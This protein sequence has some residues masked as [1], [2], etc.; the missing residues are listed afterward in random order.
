MQRCFES[1]G[2]NYSLHKNQKDWFI[3]ADYI[4]EAPPKEPFCVRW[5]VSPTTL[6]S[7]KKKSPRPKPND[8]LATLLR[9]G[10]LE[11]CNLYQS[12]LDPECVTVLA[13]ESIEQDEDIGVAS[14]ELMEQ[15]PFDDFI[16]DLKDVRHL[17]AYAIDIKS[18]LP[19]YKGPELLMSSVLFGNEVRFLNDPTW[20]GNG[21]TANVEA[22]LAFTTGFPVI[23]IRTLCKINA[24]DELLMDWGDHCVQLLKSDNGGKIPRKFPSLRRFINQPWHASEA[25][26]LGGKS[27]SRPKEMD[28]VLDTPIAALDPLLFD[29]K[30]WTRPNSMNPN[31]FTDDQ[32]DG[33]PTPEVLAI[34]TACNSTYVRVPPADMATVFR[35]MNCSWSLCPDEVAGETPEPF[36]FRFHPSVAPAVR[37]A[38]PYLKTTHHGLG[39]N[40]RKGRLLGCGLYQDS[41]DP[42][43]LTVFAHEKIVKKKIIGAVCAEIF[44]EKYLNETISEN[45]KHIWTYPLPSTALLGYNGPN[46]VFSSLHFANEAR[47]INDPGWKREAFD[48]PNVQLGARYP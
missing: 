31:P 26:V 22:R 38:M 6:A 46:L 39:R 10:R 12:S 45:I 24:G 14:G 8:P 23:V 1:L 7:I 48:T 21:Q 42:G 17:W 29:T 34:I 44:E 41:T 47:F 3:P 20:K 2:C 13:M 9:S 19:G 32:G 15:A 36:V 43:N 33:P 5:S 11:K 40:V 27:K 16:D 4:G 37:N 35:Q 30:R 18:F 25:A 28:Q